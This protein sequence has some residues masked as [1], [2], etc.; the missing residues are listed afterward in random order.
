[1]RYKENCYVEEKQQFYS[2]SFWERKLEIAKRRERLDDPASQE[3]LNRRAGAES[4][5]D[6]MHHRTSKRTR[7]TGKFKVTNASIAKAIGIELKLVSRY[8]NEES[9]S[10]KTVA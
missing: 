9:E 10:E 2:F 7:F 3:F 4:M 6:E 5:V 1:M 8:L